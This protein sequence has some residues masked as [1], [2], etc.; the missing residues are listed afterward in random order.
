MPFLEEECGWFRTAARA[1]WTIFNCVEELKRLGF[2]RNSIEILES[3]LLTIKS[4]LEQ[5]PY[6]SQE[7]DKRREEIALFYKPDRQPKPV[8]GIPDHCWMAS[9]KDPVIYDLL[10]AITQAINGAGQ[11]L[12]TIGFDPAIILKL[13]KGIEALIQWL[14]D[15]GPQTAQE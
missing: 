8:S 14:K 5:S 4:Q 3:T 15:Y 11:I 10:N 7:F 13:A 2:S 12:S 6:Y 9:Q 1:Y